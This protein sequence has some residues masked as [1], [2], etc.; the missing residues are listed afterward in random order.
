M[1]KGK[2]RYRCVS[3]KK[4][5]PLYEQVLETVRSHKVLGL[6]IQDNLKWNEYI[7][8]IVSKESKRLQGVSKVRSDCKLY[9]AR[10]FYC[11]F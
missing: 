4:S 8:M 3:L 7:C 10:R 9:F 11:F 5:F 2:K 1:R 6:V